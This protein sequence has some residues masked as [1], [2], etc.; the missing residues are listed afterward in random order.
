MTDG[1][2][3]QTLPPGLSVI[4]AV[5]TGMIAAN[6]YYA[7]PL[8]GPISE[9]LGLSPQAAGLIVMLTQAGYGVGLFFIVSLGDMV[10][11]RTLTIALILIATIGLLGAA[12][13]IHALPFLISA[14]LIGLGSVAVQVLVPFAAHMAPDATR[15]RV[16]GN[17][18]GGLMLGIMLARPVASMIAEYLT[19]RATFWFSATNMIVLIVILSNALPKRTPPSGLGYHVLLASMVR[20]VIQTPI[21]QRRAAYHA[22][23]FGA[24]SLFWT[25]VPLLLAS[26]AFH[27][28]QGDIA[29]FSLAGIAGAIATPIAG[30]LGDRGWTRQAT[31]IAMLAVILAFAITQIAPTGTRASLVLLIAA[32]FL[33]DF[34]VAVNLTLGQRAIFSLEAEN[35]ARLNGLYMA[36]FFTGGAIGSSVG[37]LFYATYGWSLTCWLGAVFPSLAVLLHLRLTDNSCVAQYKT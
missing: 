35:R 8:A 7:Q 24:F 30:W 13:S 33:L 34:G 5:A 27:F 17:V 31:T 9:S 2:T 21:L 28:S 1:A 22:C 23:L 25:T 36:I 11:N 18:M 4:L 3:S 16:I 20:I 15:G 6:I 10:E 29:L 26:S 32:A 37:A 14:G 12:L 19:W